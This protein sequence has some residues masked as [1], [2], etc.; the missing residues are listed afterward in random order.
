[1]IPYCDSPAQSAVA[2]VLG[3]LLGGTLALAFGLSLPTTLLLAGLLGGC[4]DL[5]AH[6][7]RGDPQFRAAVTRVRR[8]VG[9][10]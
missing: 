7:V 1:M 10:S 3:G 5:L 6:V 8:R 2:A 9:E 4:G